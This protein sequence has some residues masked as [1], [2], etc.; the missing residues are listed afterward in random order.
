MMFYRRCFAMGSSIFGKSKWVFC[1]KKDVVE[2]TS[3]NSACGGIFAKIAGMISM[4]IQRNCPLKKL[5]TFGIEANAE[6]LIVVHSPKALHDIILSHKGQKQVL[7]GG[8]NILLT[9]NLAGL[10]IK[11]EIGGIEIFLDNEHD[12]LAKVGGGVVWHDLVLWAV[13]QE[14]GGIENLSLIPGTVGASPIQNIGAYGVELRDVF[15]SLE[16]FDLTTGEFK[17]FH[18]EECHFGYRDSIFKQAY[19]G[20][21]FIVNVYLTLHKS[22]KVNTAY[23]DIQRTLQEMGVDNP[24]IKDVSNAVIKI[25]QSKLPDPAAIGNAGSFFKNPELE[26]IDFQLFIEQFPQAPNYPQPDGRVKVPAGWLI[27]Q[28]GWKGQRFGDSGCH[29]KQ[30]LVLVNY[31]HAKGEEILALAKKIQASVREKFGV[32][33]S[34]EVN[35]W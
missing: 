22:P 13:E 30:A 18:K 35:I 25:R 34:P 7:G 6:E 17:V 2:E 10:T 29:T 15:H 9:G 26:P 20:R 19:K 21:F 12:V 27:E 4:E 23:G 8:S 28:A 14:L 31:G 3:P 33:I 16:A 11:N 32:L 24:S 5:N 1:R